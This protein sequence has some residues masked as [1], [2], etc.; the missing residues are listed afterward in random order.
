MADFHAVN[1]ETIVAAM[2][3][4]DARYPNNDYDSWRTKETYAHAVDFNQSLYPPKY[5]IELVTGIPSAEFHTQAAIAPLQ[6]YGF[7]VGN[8][9]SLLQKYGFSFG[10]KEEIQAQ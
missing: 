2:K 8:K 3:I 4:Y 7:S 10:N 5:L 9:I 6:R 1:G